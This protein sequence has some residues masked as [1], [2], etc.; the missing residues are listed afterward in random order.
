MTTPTWVVGSG[1][2]LG[3]TVAHELRRR[4][5]CVRTS[6]VPW[7]DQNAAIAV[8]AED[9]RTLVRSAA[10]APWRLAWCAGA[11][12]TGTDEGTLETENHVF[13]AVLATLRDASAG[14]AERG[15]VV[16]SSSAG[17]VYA[18]VGGAPHTEDS[19][20][21]PLAPYGWAK[22]AA[23][24]T[25]AEFSNTTGA[26]VVSARFA[27]LYGP[28]QNLTKPQGLI[29]HL[30]RGFLLG[31]PISIYVSLDTIRDY[32][33]IADAAAMIADTL[34]SAADRQRTSTVKIYGSSR[35][36]TVG[37][38][39]AE[40]RAVFRRRPRVVLATSDQTA[41]Q[42]RDL[43]LRSVVWPELDRRPHTPLATG[44]AATLEATRR[45]L[46]R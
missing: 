41:A 43:R 31:Q 2:L 3:S 33:Y 20:V 12:V 4:G 8:L 14:R 1:G 26:A 25:A 44:V 13:R 23:E 29:S 39:L 42:A 16:H 7:T 11:G 37:A 18:G 35:S 45:L 17:A 27:N 6:N 24:H 28:G 36:V 32:L 9:A 40:C 46:L 21:A 10:G 15:T 30:C 5:H 34:A 19:P 22:L 38:I